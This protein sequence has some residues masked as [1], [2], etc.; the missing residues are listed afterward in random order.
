MN[1]LLG[2]VVTVVVAVLGYL[3]A[4]WIGTQVLDFDRSPISPIILAI[5]L[6]M[7]ANQF[8]AFK[9]EWRQGFSFCSSTIL[10]LGIVLLGL[11]L[12]LGVASSVAMQALPVIVSCIVF[13]LVMVIFVGRKLGLSRELATLIA[14]G[15]SV[16]GATAI[17]AT[18]PLIRAKQ[19]ETSY[20]IATITLFGLIAMFAYPYLAALVFDGNEMYVGLFLG[21]AIHETAQVAGA[22]FIYEQQHEAPTALMVATVT[23]LVRNLSLVV[24]IPLI[25]VYFSRFIDVSESTRSAWYKNIPV[26]IVLFI[27]MVVVRTVGDSSEIAFGFVSPESWAQAVAIATTAAKWCLTIAMAGIGLN[28]SI[29]VLRNLGLKP[30]VL[31]TIAATAVG[32]IAILVIKTVSAG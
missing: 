24:L 27:L 8:I 17:V 26:F 19:A 2:T 20:A 30:L 9:D 28:T 7:L 11:K 1:T 21:T 18:A 31:G 25:S 6:G 15:T 10:K 3:S 12:S 23:K 32:G 4:D 22:G 29:A 5:I 16:C 13:A 14:V